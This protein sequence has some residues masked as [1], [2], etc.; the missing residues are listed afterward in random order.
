[1][2]RILALQAAVYAR[3]FGE[4]P[5]GDHADY[6]RATERAFDAAKL[7]GTIEGQ[8]LLELLRD[9]MAALVGVLATVTDGLKNEPGS[10]MQ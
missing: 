3:R 2:A 4:L 6:M 1:M 7:L 5:P 10:R 9:G 8:R